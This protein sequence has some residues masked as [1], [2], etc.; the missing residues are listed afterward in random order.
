[1]NI[2]STNTEKNILMRCYCHFNNMCG[3]QEYYEDVP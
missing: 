2:T 1:L 3:N